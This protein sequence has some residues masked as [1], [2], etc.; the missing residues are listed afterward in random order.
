MGDAGD[1]AA[2]R[3][4]PLGVDQVLLRGVEFEQR[5]FGLFLGGAQFSFRLALGDGVL[6]KHVHGARHGADLVSGGGA[7]NPAVQIA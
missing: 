7:L 1:E 5:C 2:E 4:Q 6:A 3:G